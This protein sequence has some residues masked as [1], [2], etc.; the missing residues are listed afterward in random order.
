MIG[1]RSGLGAICA[2]QRIAAWNIP[3]FSARPMPRMLT[4]MSPSA[5]RCVTF[6]SID[7]SIQ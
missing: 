7:D 6:R 2:S 5:G 3:N 1:V 4:K